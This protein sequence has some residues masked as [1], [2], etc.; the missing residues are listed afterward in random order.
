MLILAHPC[1]HDIWDLAC[2]LTNI[3][4]LL[5]PKNTCCHFLLAPSSN[6]THPATNMRGAVAEPIE[7][8]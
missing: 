2:G 5:Y 7:Q 4:P 6:P 1:F 3:E 8:Q